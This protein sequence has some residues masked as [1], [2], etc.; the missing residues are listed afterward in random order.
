MREYE[1]SVEGK[2]K[3]ENFNFHF[4]FEQCWQFHMVALEDVMVEVTVVVILR[5][6]EVV[7]VVM[8]EETAVEA[9]WLTSNV[10]SASSMVTLLM[11]ATF[12]LI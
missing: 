12:I 2:G 11:Y 5:L 4:G 1:C 6:I 7:I 3:E 8:L 10:K 9:D